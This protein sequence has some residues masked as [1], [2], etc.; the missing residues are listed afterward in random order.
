MDFRSSSIEDDKLYFSWLPTELL[1]EI[2][3]HIHSKKVYINF[4]SMI[5][6]RITRNN[7]IYFESKLFN[8]VYDTSAKNGK[9]TSISLYKRSYYGLL[10][11]IRFVNDEVCWV[12]ILNE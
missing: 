12:D 8:N 3:K 9:L 6:E 4:I 1:G 10:A 7:H 2:I 11:T 5:N